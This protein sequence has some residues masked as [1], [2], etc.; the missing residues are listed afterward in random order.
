MSSPVILIDNRDSFVYNLKDSLVRLGRKVEVYRNHFSAA[1]LLAMAKAQNAV[2][3]LSPGPGRPRDAGSLMQLIELAQGQVPAIGICLGHQAILEVA[4]ADLVRAATP[5]HGKI[6][7]LEHD[8]EGPFEGLA[9]PLRIARYHSLCVRQAPDRFHVH[10]RLEGM[11]M[12]IA[13]PEARQY[14]L[15]FHPESIATP[16]GDRLL[17]GLIQTAERTKG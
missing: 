12:A 4:G 17:A 10:A 7:I 9:S 6:S 16:Q 13:D 2:L 5:V 8:G 3:V 14:G 15:Q 11:L 1:S